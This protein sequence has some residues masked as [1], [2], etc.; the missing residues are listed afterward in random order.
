[1]NLV[2]K[3]QQHVQLL[4]GDQVKSY[5]DGLSIKSQAFLFINK[6]F[7]NVFALIALELDHLA[8]LSIIDDGAIAS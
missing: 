4:S 1:M 7:L 2:R 5:L 8:H 3:G 6:E